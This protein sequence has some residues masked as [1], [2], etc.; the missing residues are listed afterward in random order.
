MVAGVDLFGQ[1]RPCA[2][3]GGHVVGQ[4][5][6]EGRLAETGDDLLADRFVAGVDVVEMDRRRVGGPFRPQAGDRAGQQP[7]HSAHPLEVAERRRLAGQGFEDFGV[8]GVAR[9][10]GL[11]G[12]GAA[13]VFDQRAAA[14]RPALP[15][16]LDR[17]TGSGFVDRVE[18]AAAEHLDGLVLLGRVEQGRLARGD[19]LRLRHAVGDEPVLLAIGVGGPP[20]LADRQSVDQGRA[21]S[22]FHGFEQRSQEGGQLA[23]GPRV[24]AQLAQIDRQLVEQDQR[25]RAPEQ[26]AQGLG[27][28]GDAVLVAPAD[29][30][31]ALSAGE[32]PGDFTPRGAGQHA[33]AHG[34]AVGRVGV[35]AVEGGD[36]DAAARYRRRVDELRGVRYPRH[37]PRGMGQGDQPVG[38]AAAI[39]RIEPEDRRGLASRARQPPAYVGQQVAKPPRGPGVGEET[40]RVAVFVVPRPPPGG[41]ASQI[42]REIGFRDRPR[43]DVGARAAGLEDRRDGHAGGREAGARRGGAARAPEPRCGSAGTAKPC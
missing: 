24:A 37:A 28:G 38:L 32:G 14:R 34:P 33:L 42:R 11:D 22:A 30:L 3:A 26:L 6:H 15:V 35:L 41:D 36:A 1:S 23:A 18:Q 21:R 40:R 13:G 39:G 31:P 7:E 4:R 17:R 8:K 43:Q 5:R 16:R 19:A 2:P 25:R 10:E 20:V 9:P 12:C 27:P 29:P